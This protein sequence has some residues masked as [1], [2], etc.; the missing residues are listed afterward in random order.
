M[1]T[2]L[3]FCQMVNLKKEIAEEIDLLE[4]KVS[5]LLGDKLL[6][7]AK[8]TL[9]DG[10]TEGEYQ[11]LLKSAQEYGKE[12][13]EHPF[14]MQMIFAYYIFALLEDKY[15]KAGI[16]Q[17]IYEQTMQDFRYRVL[18]CQDVYQMTGI[19]VAWWY[20]IFCNLSLHHLDILEFEK[21][22]ANFSYSAKGVTVEKGDPILAI[23]IPPNTPFTRA[24]IT[25][26]LQESYKYYGLQG[27]VAYQCES[28]L[29]YPDFENIFVAGGNIQKFRSFF[30]ILKSKDNETFEDCWRM[31]MVGEIESLDDLPTDTRL[32]RNM[33]AH[34]KNGG[35]TGE[36]FGVLVFDGENIV[37]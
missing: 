5:A 26:A 8:E 3:E 37:D 21:T 14:R 12:I 25:K 24:T 4:K 1:K 17:K 2:V 11:Q 15:R 10:I 34:L 29:L 20:R 35:K 22:V 27:R 18:E 9:K 32:Q 7:L 23:H 16:P 6:L 36:G 13:N 30:Q 28:W 31:F 19:F 33:L